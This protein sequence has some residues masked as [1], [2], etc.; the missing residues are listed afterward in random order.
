MRKPA[1]NMT[2]GFIEVF[3]QHLPQSVCVMPKLKNRQQWTADINVKTSGGSNTI[4]EANQ[5]NRS[6]KNQKKVSL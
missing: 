2:E 3:R 6:A 5:S 1:K 4:T